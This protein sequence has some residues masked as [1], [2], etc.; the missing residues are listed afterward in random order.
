MILSFRIIDFQKS[1]VKLSFITG[2]LTAV[3]IGYFCLFRHIVRESHSPPTV[4]APT[5]RTPPVISVNSQLIPLPQSKPDVSA[6]PAS[7]KLIELQNNR[8]SDSTSTQSAP[9]KPKPLTPVK[10][11]STE[12]HH[13]NNNNLGFS[14][15]NEFYSVTSEE[16]NLIIGIA[17]NI[18]PKYFAIFA[19]SLRQ[20]AQSRATVILFVNAPISDLL[21][22]LAV[23]YQLILIIFTLQSLQPSFIRNY[24]PSSLRWILM[25]QLFTENYEFFKQYY[26]K[27]L[28]LDT[29]DS[30]FQLS[31]F[32]LIS[33]NET[34]L[35]VFGEDK[36]SRIIDCGWN[37]GWIRDCFGDSALQ[38]VGDHPIICSGITLG[39]FHHMHLYLQTM[40]NALLGYYPKETGLKDPK[41]RFPSCERNGVDQGLHNYLIHA[42]KFPFEVSVKYP[43]MF[44]IVNMQAAVD[45]TPLPD[46]PS[47]VVMIGEGKPFAVVHQYDRNFDLQLALGKQYVDWID[48]KH[49]ISEWK[50]ME[51]CNYFDTVEGIDLL[52]GKCDA[53][54][55]RAMTAASC[56]TAC[57]N[58]GSRF[59]KLTG[60]INKKDCTGF[61]YVNGVCYF[62]DCSIHDIEQNVKNYKNLAESKDPSALSSLREDGAIS[63]FL[64]S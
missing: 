50:Q 60:N 12:D 37:S 30:A 43:D 14:F 24:H 42:H 19:G 47:T 32:P 18:D 54:S 45:I 10:P 48:W 7:Q 57:V 58:R 28:T 55:T 1:K 44:P 15:N 46:D 8:K 3:C 52:R 39:T 41:T 13:Q 29:R 40:S 38:D 23:Q 21:Q 64:K 16:R 61:T 31:P 63:A 26:D 51:T 62:K 49:P 33:V 25:N 53:G 11:I 22:K 59:D 34:R 17:T 56:C 4:Q 6:I 36:Q 35:F 9:L 2:F 27:V 20:R 5:L